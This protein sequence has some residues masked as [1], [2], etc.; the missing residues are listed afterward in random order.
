MIGT[1][2]LAA[3]SWASPGQ[4]PFLGDMTAAVDTYKDIPA[5]A[6]ERLKQQIRRREYDDLVVISRDDITGAVSNWGGLRQMHF[7]AGRL[8]EAVDRSKWSAWHIERGLIYCEEHH[9]LL[10]PFVC[11]NV[12]RVTRLAPKPSRPAPRPQEPE[13][14][15]EVP[16]PSTA[17]LVALSLFLIRLMRMKR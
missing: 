13:K 10:V 14:R 8:C 4:N 16:E 17:A 15:N 2:V 7:A 5:P 12:S 3:C 9:C 11:N 6:R 1:A